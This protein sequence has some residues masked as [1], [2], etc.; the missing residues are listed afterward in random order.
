MSAFNEKTN[1]NAE[2]LDS[3]KRTCTLFLTDSAPAPQHQAYGE[4][5]F[6]EIY[7]PWIQF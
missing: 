3:C 2:L 5:P 4:L 6:G 1:L 7:L